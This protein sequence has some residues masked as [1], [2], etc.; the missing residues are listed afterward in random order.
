MSLLRA[1]CRTISSMRLSSLL[2]LV[3]LGAV[4]VAP[5]AYYILRGTS[6]GDESAS[7]G[8][9][10]SAGEHARE[11]MRMQSE[12][13]RKA[14]GLIDDDEWGE[15][16]K[17]LCSCNRISLGMGM[18][19][20]QWGVKF[21]KRLQEAV[22]IMESVR[23]EMRGMEK[24]R[25]ELQVQVQAFHREIKELNEEATRRRQELDRLQSMAQQARLARDE[26]ERRNTPEIRAPI[27]LQA[28]IAN[29]VRVAPPGDR[30][31]CGETENCFDYS[32]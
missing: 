11:H 18:D 19:D 15:A 26:F 3:V 10:S 17:C 14:L 7:L 25:S 6:G 16:G 28:S 20:R 21:Q 30:A 12:L 9:T 22:R 13:A 27:S 4:T 32:R 24:Q 2:L 31:A 5:A 29:N 8:T 1:V 23:E